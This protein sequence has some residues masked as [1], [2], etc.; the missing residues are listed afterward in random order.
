M[1]A[2]I[3]MVSNQPVNLPIFAKPAYSGGQN[4]QFSA[5]GDGHARPVDCF[6]PQPSAFVFQRIQEHDNFL[7]GVTEGLNVDLAAQFRGLFET[8]P[9]IADEEPAYGQFPVGLRRENR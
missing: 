5:I 1:R 8:L 4:D 7:C 6:V 3:P 9:V 2:G